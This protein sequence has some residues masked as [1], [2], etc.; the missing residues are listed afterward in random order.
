MNA[1][2]RNR[3]R[4]FTVYLLEEE[5]A[6]LEAKKDEAGMT[7]SDYIRN[8]IL[9]GAVHE[10]TIFSKN[11]AEKMIYEINQIGNNLNQIAYRANSSK[12]I[13]QHDF[14]AMYDS[15]MQLL[16]AYDNFVRENL[17]KCRA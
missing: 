13:D 6:I 17:D 7:K 16:S 15:Y 12:N 2:F 14:S 3:D 11:D 8:M 9:F 1:P 10:R 4:R 5:M